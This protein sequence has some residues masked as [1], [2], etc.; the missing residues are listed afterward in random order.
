MGKSSLLNALAGAE[1][2]IVTPIAG[3]T[4][5]KVS[6]TIQIEG[7]P[8]HVIDTAGLRDLADTN[9]AIER[10]GIDRS[11]REIE[12]ADAVLFLHDVTRLE[13]PGYAAGDAV[14]R[15]RLP[16]PLVEA[17]RVLDVHNKS[18]LLPINAPAAK[19]A[20]SMCL[21]ARTGAGLDALRQRLLQMAGW[22]EHPEGV[23]TA[24][25]RHV[26]ALAQ[27]RHHIEVAAATSRSKMPALDL[28][29]EELRLAQRALGEIVGHST[30]DELLGE[31]FS[32]FCIGK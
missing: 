5:D 11:W 16:R 1:L 14:I 8:V 12:G 29:A 6:Q 27:T 9:D 10:I 18:D 32:R 24:R 25:A 13:E 20:D 4:R 31:I 21:S 28:L 15:Q 30:P 2:A 19:A 26:Q 23:Y 3:T 17:L 7:V 22:H